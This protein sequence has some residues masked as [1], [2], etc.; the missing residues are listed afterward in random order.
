ML[1]IDQATTPILTFTTI[2]RCLGLPPRLPRPTGDMLP[3]L[4]SSANST[5]Y[6]KSLHLIP[7]LHVTPT[8]TQTTPDQTLHSIGPQKP[9]RARRN[10]RHL[11]PRRRR[12]RCPD[13]H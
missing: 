3:S 1:P 11:E 9:P 13:Q 8:L 5:T 10:L 6:A 12:L 4:D 2:V 7:A